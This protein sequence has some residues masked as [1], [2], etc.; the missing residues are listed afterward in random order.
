MN[1]VRFKCCRDQAVIGCTALEIYDS[2][3]KMKKYIFVQ[4]FSKIKKN[5]RKFPNFRKNDGF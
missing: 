3:K 1:R 5:V 4:N 2:Y